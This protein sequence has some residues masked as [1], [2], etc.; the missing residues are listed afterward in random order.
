MF[1][2]WITCLLKYHSF[3]GFHF[4]NPIKVRGKSLSVLIVLLHIGLCAWCSYGSL[5]TFANEIDNLMEHLDALNFLL[6]YTTSA[7]TYALI[8]YDSCA[9]RCAEIKFWQ[10]YSQIDAKFCEQKST[11]NRFNLFVMVLMYVIDASISILSV[12]SEHTTSSAYLIRHHIYLIVCNN[13]ILFYVLHLN[14][15]EIQYRKLEA[16]LN[17]MRQQKRFNWI[18]N[19]YGLVCDMSDQLNNFFGWSQLASVLLNFHSILTFFNFIY[20]QI[21]R[22]FDKF[23]YGWYFC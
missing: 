16:G 3:F 18:R 22:K 12:A 2:T 11:E 15:I 19:Y 1:P 6:Y 21:H 20:R 5:I 14:V 10:I 8:I 13:H 4:I 7:L 9:N 23:N 17:E